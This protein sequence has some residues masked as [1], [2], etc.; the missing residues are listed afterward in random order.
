MCEPYGSVIQYPDYTETGLSVQKMLDP[1]VELDYLVQESHKTEE[2]YSVQTNSVLIPQ[3]I[4]IGS[5]IHYAKM[6][7]GHSEAL[8]KLGIRSNLL[9][10]DTKYE[11]SWW[12]RKLSIDG[13]FHG[14][15]K[16]DAFESCEVYSDR[17]CTGHIKK[18]RQF[19]EVSMMK[20]DRPCVYFE[21]FKHLFTKK[22]YLEFE[23]KL[24]FIFNFKKGASVDSR[25]LI[26]NKNILISIINAALG[27]TR[28]RGLLVPEWSDEDKL[29]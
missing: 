1:Y 5:H 20:S 7:K 23:D 3:G 27:I 24:K 12:E 17:I 26:T 28:K 14:I 2:K 11:I 15:D 4:I 6:G 22:G 18:L 25:L 21:Q 10:V 19:L 13:P 8:R 16:E 9:P 29:W